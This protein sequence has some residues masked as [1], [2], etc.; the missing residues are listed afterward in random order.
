MKKLILFF[1]CCWATCFASAQTDSIRQYN[2]GLMLPFQ[3]QSTLNGIS[4]FFNAPDF[5]TASRISLNSY[6][7]EAL[8][9]YQGLLL[10]LQTNKDSIHIDLHTYDCWNNDSVTEVWLKKPELKNLDVLIGPSSTANARLAAEFCLKNK[11]LNIQPF[12][13]SKSLTLNNPYH[14]KL[15]PTIDAHVDNIFASVLDSFAGGNVI[16]YAPDNEIGTTT[17]TRFDSLF[18]HYNKTATIKFTVNNLSYKKISAEKKKL[19][20]YLKLTKRNIVIITAFEG[21]FVNNTLRLL[22]EE[23]SETNMV[24]YGMP[25]WLNSEVMR[26]DYL[27]NFT[28]CITDGFYADTARE[29]T[30]NFAIEYKQL[31][32]KEPT[33]MSY[34]GYDA[35]NFLFYMLSTHGKDFP[36]KIMGERYTGAGYKFDVVKQLNAAGNIDYYENRHVNVFKIEDYRLKKIW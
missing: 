28:A 17:A 4:D 24:L 31:Y 36:E 23:Q 5:F 29:L 18:A 35:M 27:N 2:V 16:I 3:T 10:A 14:I 8:D 34:S 32:H 30:R 1:C 21:S 19:T 22:T 6:S 26:L 9:F 11:I 33:P 13:P 20:D 12:T 15:A 25:T 7:E